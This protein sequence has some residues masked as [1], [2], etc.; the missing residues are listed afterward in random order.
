VL[1]KKEKKKAKQNFKI[2]DHEQTF[3][4]GDRAHL[5]H[6]A[7]SLAYSDTYSY[8]LP[9]ALSE[10]MQQKESELIVWRVLIWHLRHMAKVLVYQASFVSLSVSIYLYLA[11][12]CLIIIKKNKT[13]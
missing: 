8:E 12:F 6:S 11:I 10:Y 3:T 13:K 9:G 5:L 1:K 2:Y 4:V 7:Y